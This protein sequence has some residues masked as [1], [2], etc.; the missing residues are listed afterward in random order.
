MSEEKN[1]S[2]EEKA[3]KARLEEFKR[4]DLEEQSELLHNAYLK[5]AESVEQ[6]RWN[7]LARLISFLK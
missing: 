1:V 3:R 7:R 5:Y 2:E 4:L 6:K